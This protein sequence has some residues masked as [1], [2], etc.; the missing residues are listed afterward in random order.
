MTLIINDR[1]RGAVVSDIENPLFRKLYSLGVVDDQIEGKFDKDLLTRSLLIKRNAVYTLLKGDYYC[2][3]NV[4]QIS[5]T[6]I[7]ATDF[8]DD[9]GQLT[10][11]RK[12]KNTGV[13]N[14]M[15]MIIFKDCLQTPLKNFVAD[16]LLDASINETELYFKINKNIHIWG[17]L[18]AVEML[19]SDDIKILVEVTE[20]QNKS[21][22]LIDALSENR[23]KEQGDDTVHLPV[24]SRDE[25]GFDRR[26]RQWIRRTM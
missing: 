23:R 20:I 11:Y 18:G 19:S 21:G 3:G 5:N 17:Y 10:F 1:G 15:V 4:F 16:K 2:I 9:I 8:V 13:L 6:H 26:I 12:Y 7:H 14:Y 25:W 22:E 24:I